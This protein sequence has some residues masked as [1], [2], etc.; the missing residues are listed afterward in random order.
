MDVLVRKQSNAE[1]LV[2]LHIIS[3]GG[4]YGAERMLLEHVRSARGSIEHR[5][6][7]IDAP[8]TVVQKF[9]GAGVICKLVR[10]MRCLFRLVQ[11]QTDGAILNCHGYKALA[12][13][14][15]CS[16][17]KRCLIIATLHGFTPISLKQ[18]YYGWV[19]LYLCRLPKVKRVACVSRSI[20]KIAEAAGVP[21]E[22]IA[23]VPNAIATRRMHEDARSIF[24]TEPMAP[25]VGFI[26]RLRV[27]KGPDIFL[28]CLRQIRREMPQARAVILGDGPDRQLME[29]AI[30]DFGL[31]GAVELIGYVDDVTSWLRRIDVLILSSR[32]EGTPIVLLEAMQAG[33][34]IAAFAVGGVPELLNNGTCGLLADPGDVD[35]LAAHALSLLRDSTLRA[36]V[37]HAARVRCREHYGMERCAALWEALYCQ[38]ALS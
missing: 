36:T 5:V 14:V 38:V 37:S 15:V 19:N 7:F 27:E 10:S 1:D 28:A 12:W 31:E 18:R 6:I 11:S 25:I 26:G 4:F 8:G 21:R 32:T 17:G 13:A 3:S 30:R 9:E 29:Q 24:R 2:V 34:P 33:V 20:A 22:K 16:L 23:V 35:G